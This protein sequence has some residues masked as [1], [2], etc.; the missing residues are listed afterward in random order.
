MLNNLI[1]FLTRWRLGLFMFFQRIVC[2]IPSHIIRDLIYRHLFR[3]K[4]G[5][6]AKVSLGVEIRSPWKVKIGVNSIVENNCLL[7]GRRNLM[8]GNNVNISHG[9][10]IW[11][12][13]HDVQSSEFAR[14]GSEVNIRDRAWICSRATILPGV[15]I[16][17]GAVVASGSVV[18]KSVEPFTIVGGVPAKKIGMRNK[19]LHYQ[20][21][22]RIPFS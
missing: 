1:L 16:G 4:L 17:E 5:M 7:D 13:H 14:I 21:K 8:I 18:T 10:W 19:D 12:L 9:V 11:S 22:F 2:Y 15:E 3:M 6:G 20:L